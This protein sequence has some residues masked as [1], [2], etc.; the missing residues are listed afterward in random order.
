MNWKEELPESCPPKEATQPNG[1]VVYRLS[2]S[3]TSIEDEY[4]SQRKICPTC[5]FKG[6][7]ECLSRSLSVYDDLNK[8]KQLQKLPRFKN[9]WKGILELKLSIN[10]G[11]IQQTFKANHYS[12]WRT[13]EFDISQVNTIQ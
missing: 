7:S 11:M 5:V 10:D 12:W 6:V 2:N 1:K 8:C 9:R 3:G 13:Q 4:Q